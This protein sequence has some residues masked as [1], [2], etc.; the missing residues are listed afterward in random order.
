LAY[1]TLCGGLL[2][3]K[4]W[5]SQEPRGTDLNTVSLRKHKNMVDVW[6]GWSLFQKLLNLLKKIADKYK[7]SISNVAVSYIL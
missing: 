2:S 5:D 1:G 3:E 7:F 6:G 4:Y